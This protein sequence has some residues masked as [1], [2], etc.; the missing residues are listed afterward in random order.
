M[1]EYKEQ[2]IALMKPIFDKVSWP[3]VTD[4]CK[5]IEEAFMKWYE[6]GTHQLT[7]QGD[8]VVERQIITDKRIDKVREDYIKILESTVISASWAFAKAIAQNI[9]K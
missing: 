2:F 4:M 1:T 5:I 7:P 6:I 9:Y 3:M 8:D